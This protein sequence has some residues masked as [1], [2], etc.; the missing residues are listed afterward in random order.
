MGFSLVTHSPDVLEPENLQLVIDCPFC[1]MPLPYPGLTG[2]GS[3][4]M[5]ECLA[6]DVYFPFE[7]DEVYAD[8][9]INNVCRLLSPD[10]PTSV[11][12][13]WQTPR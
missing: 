7:A 9:R 12:R 11:A 5:G 4:P 8:G 6:C 2:D 10:R 3:L 13:L 1:R